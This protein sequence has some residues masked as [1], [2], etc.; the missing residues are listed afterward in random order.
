MKIGFSS[1]VC[2]SWDLDTIATKAA[3]MGFDCFELRGLG[4]ELHLPLVP[5][6]ASNPEG[7]RSALREKNVELVCLGTSASLDS[8]DRRELARQQGIIGEFVELAARLKCPFVRIFVGEVQRRDNLRRAQSR[9]ADALVSLA[10]MAARHGVTILVENGGDFPSSDTLWFLIDAVSHPAIK[11][12]W[13]QCQARTVCERA[14]I[15]IPRLGRKIGM[16]HICDAAFDDFGLLTEYRQPGAGDVEIGRMI[17]LL[18]G[19][20]YEGC[21]VFE[22]PKLWNPSLPEP[23]AVL[24]AV[25][26]HL[27]DCI[28]AKQAV[29]TAYKGDKRPAKFAARRVAT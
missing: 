7:V 3:E 26:K 14:T 5:A 16:V 23:D 9:I 6:L 22:W 4:G 21:L 29:L 25:Q 11:C 28:D 18:K 15:S 8:K 20:V 17:E 1:L 24:P 27:R 13:S 19:I 2:P 12:C 10:P